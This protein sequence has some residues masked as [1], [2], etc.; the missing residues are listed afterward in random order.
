MEAVLDCKDRE[1]NYVYVY[2]GILSETETEE[3]FRKENNIGYV[4]GGYYIS[5]ENFYSNKEV[6]EDKKFLTFPVEVS[7]LTNAAY[8][9]AQFLTD[10]KTGK[11]AWLYYVNMHRLDQFTHFKETIDYDLIMHTT[12][13]KGYEEIFS[14]TYDTEEDET[15]TIKLLYSKSK[16]YIAVLTTDL[17]MNNT[18]RVYSPKGMQ[19]TKLLFSKNV[20]RNTEMWTASSIISLFNYKPG[21]LDYQYIISLYDELMSLAS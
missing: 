13:S 12:K 1:I 21:K 6:P 7:K 8:R 5:L 20:V 11:T 19:S 2:T 14:D 3:S 4:K 9:G 15:M 10:S 18:I 16:N 17:F